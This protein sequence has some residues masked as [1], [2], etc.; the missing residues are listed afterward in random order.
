LLAGLLSL[1]FE[2]E[3]RPLLF[4]LIDLKRERKIKLADAVIA[5]TAIINNLELVTRNTDDFKGVSELE[6][7]NPFE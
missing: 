7:F 6:V 2:K 1:L 4:L 5:A 3:N